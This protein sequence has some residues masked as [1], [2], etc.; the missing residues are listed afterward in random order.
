MRENDFSKGFKSCSG[1]VMVEVS[2]EINDG[3]IN[4][5]DGSVA[6]GC[7]F[8]CGFGSGGVGGVGGGGIS[9]GGTGGSICDAVGALV[10]SASY[11]CDLAMQL[12][13][14]VQ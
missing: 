2:L 1:A 11:R 5:S 7:L 12:F 14:I 8:D 6:G 3:G 10:I 13:C 9:G 4:G